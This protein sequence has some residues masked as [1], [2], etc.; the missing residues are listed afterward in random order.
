VRLLPAVHRNSEN[1]QHPFASTATEAHCVYYAVGTLSCVSRM[2]DGR[3]SC[4]VTSCDSSIRDVDMWYRVLL[5]SIVRILIC[6]YG[7]SH[8]MGLWTMAGLCM[9]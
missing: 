6:K 4:L 3:Q 2:N 1:K 7:V 5:P 9:P 8:H